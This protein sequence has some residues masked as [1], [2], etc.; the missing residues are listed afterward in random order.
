[1]PS[2][3]ENFRDAKERLDFAMQTGSYSLGFVLD[4]V[5]MT[6]TRRYDPFS[7]LD[8][9]AFMEGTSPRRS[10]TK[11]ATAFKGKHL[12]GYWHKHHT[13]SCYMIENL[14][15]ELRRDGTINRV[16]MPH[17]GEVVTPKILSQ[18]THAI[19][20]ENYRR[21]SQEARLTGEWIVFSKRNGCNHYLALATHTEGDPATAK[22][23]Q[24]YE[25][26]DRETGWIN[27]SHEERC[28]S[29]GLR[30]VA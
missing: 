15:N 24:N 29:G 27:L 5:T 4:L 16:L 17:I 30:A 21:R 2:I 26:I 10:N 1:M 13:Q 19:V 22:R 12:R 3:D 8:E 6:N 25:K 28:A 23:V 7:V 18:M 11:P 14:R 9:I 20:H